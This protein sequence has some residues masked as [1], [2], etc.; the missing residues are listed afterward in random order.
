[1]SRHIHDI[2]C[3]DQMRSSINL[4]IDPYFLNIII[5]YCKTYDYLKVKSTIMFPAAH[6]ELQR[7]VS[8]EEFQTL[9]SI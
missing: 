4:D 8:I 7:N 2:L 1:M 6:N 9:E 3:K 5:N